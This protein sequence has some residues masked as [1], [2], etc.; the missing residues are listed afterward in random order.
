MGG[1]IRQG[2]CDLHSAGAGLRFRWTLELVALE[3]L[4]SRSTIYVHTLLGLR[5]AAW[6]LLRA[7]HHH[8]QQQQQPW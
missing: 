8:H 7:H 3:L 4:L 1:W 2:G 5:E 6:S